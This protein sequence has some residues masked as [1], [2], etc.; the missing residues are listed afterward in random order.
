M[1]SERQ[2]WNVSVEGWGVFDMEKLRQD[3][4]SL[5]EVLISIL[6]LALGVI[7]VAG[8]QLTA[9]R[10][11]QQSAF[12]TAA[13]Q[14]A[15]EMADRMRTNDNQAKLA[16]TDNP[17]L[18]VDYSSG[19]GEPKAP[20]QLCYANCTPEA[21]AQFDIYEWEKRLRAA[22]PGGRAVICRDAAPWDAKAGAFTW[23]CNPG[24]GNSGSIVIKL[25]WR[26]KGRNPDGSVV[27]ANTPFP[28]SV[29]LTVKPYTR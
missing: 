13:L 3:G 11:S 1:L 16:D 29:A 2:Q 22:L 7:G 9:L 25:G 27:A 17:F 14:L 15:S 28:P 6:V 5:I 19:T 4:F 23:T 21:L 24:T 18:K 12:Q 10:T 8:M 20:D 26:A